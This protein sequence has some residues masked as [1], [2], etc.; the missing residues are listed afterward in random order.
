MNRHSLS[1]NILIPIIL[2]L[3]LFASCGSPKDKTKTEEEHSLISEQQTNE[4]DTTSKT[5]G[6]PEEVL[7]PKVDSAKKAASPSV[8]EL[9]KLPFED[10]MKALNLVDIQT[11]DPSIKVQLMYST[12]DNFMKA[13]VYGDL[14]KAY[15]Q[16]EVAKMLVK[17]QANLK[18]AHPDYSLIIYDAARPYRVQQKMW[19]IVKGTSQQDYVAEPDAIGSI[20]NYGS[21][22]DLS[23]VDKSG[24]PL[25]MGTKFDFL[26][27]L[28]EP[29]LQD[30]FL[31]EGKLTQAQLDNREVLNKAMSE[32]GFMRISN[33]WWHFDA[34]SH[35]KRE[36]AKRFKRVP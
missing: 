30:K 24:K 27:T 22:I 26:G 5:R 31:K 6:I 1:N 14:T 18:K 19:T 23:V 21:A 20:H 33:E 4:V 16:P 34:F 8:D 13:D 3:G 15:A 11:L 36:I 17:A 10:A 35:A 32:A 28:A 9:S 7:K 25:D 29:K 2:I 12:T